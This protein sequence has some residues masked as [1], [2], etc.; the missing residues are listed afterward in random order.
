MRLHQHSNDE[1][2]LRSSSRSEKCDVSQGGGWSNFRNQT[3]K[4]CPVVLN[5]D[6]FLNLP[7]SGI[8]EFDYVVQLREDPRKLRYILFNK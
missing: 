2:E 5:K 1:K 3:F 7:Q 8:L 4:G 6:F